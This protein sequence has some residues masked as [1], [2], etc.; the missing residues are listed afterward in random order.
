MRALFCA[1]IAMMVSACAQV[2]NNFDINVLDK[3]QRGMT[4]TEVVALVGSPPTA[5][6]VS[7]NSG[8]TRTALV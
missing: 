3:I 7:T 6:S 5:R 4:E 2:G 1:A 8:K